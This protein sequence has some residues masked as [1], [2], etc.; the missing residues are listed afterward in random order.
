MDMPRGN[1]NGGVGRTLAHVVIAANLA[2][3]LW[4][5][6]CDASTE[7][8][9]VRMIGVGKVGG[10]G[11]DGLEAVLDALVLKIGASTV[12][13]SAGSVQSLGV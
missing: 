12:E 5:I 3:V 13:E 9:F 11:D 1:G 8:K 7:D 2:T 6:G 4:T 10:V